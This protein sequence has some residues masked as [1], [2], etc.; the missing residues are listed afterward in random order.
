M[1]RPR[2]RRIQAMCQA[3]LL[4]AVL[5]FAVPVKEGPEVDSL[6]KLR[7]SGDWGG[8]SSTLSNGL[9]AGG[10]MKDGG[11]RPTTGGDRSGCFH[12]P[13]GVGGLALKSPR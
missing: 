9:P 3:N 4:C 11:G 10:N 13:S 2:D 12:S 8:F 1:E 6:S 7:T 5:T